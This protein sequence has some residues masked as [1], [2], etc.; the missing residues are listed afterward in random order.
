MN[1]VYEFVGGP[2]HR[3]QFTASEIVAVYK[4]CGKGRSADF[5]EYRDAGACVPRAELDNEL[6]FEGYLGPMWD[7]T[8]V[9][10]SENGGRYEVYVLRYETQDVYDALSR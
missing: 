8:R 10:C 3:R 6:M 5:S 1:K 7:G 2:L 4:A 9:R